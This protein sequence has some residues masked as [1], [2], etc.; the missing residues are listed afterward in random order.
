[1]NEPRVEEARAFGFETRLVVELPDGGVVH[2]ESAFEGHVIMV[3]GP[4]SH[5]AVSPLDIDGRQ[6]GHVH[7]QLESG[8]DAL[9]ERARAAGAITCRTRSYANRCPQISRRNMSGVFPRTTRAPTI[10]PS[11]NMGTA[12]SDRQSVS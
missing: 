3:V 2:S 1:M 11:R 9:C 7:V 8:I 6:T 4:P 12:T 10:R 5:T